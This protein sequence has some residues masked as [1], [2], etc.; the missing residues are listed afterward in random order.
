MLSIIDYKESNYNLG[1]RIEAIMTIDNYKP[2]K[3][4]F[5]PPVPS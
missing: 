1:D 5:T 3:V 4:V 2:K